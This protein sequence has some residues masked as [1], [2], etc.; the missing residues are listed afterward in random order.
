ML[1][2]RATACGLALLAT[3]SCL[4]TPT[5]LA[6]TLRGAVGLPHHGVLTDGVA[7]PAKGVGFV[8]L[9]KDAMNWG[10]PR[11]VAAVER[12]AGRVAA[13]RPGGAALVVGDLAARHGGLVDRHRSHR[14]GRDVDLLFYA[15]APDGRPLETPGFV[16]FGPDGLAE[17][18]RGDFVRL[19][20]ERQ[21]LLV[22]ELAMDDEA[23][24]QWLFVSRPVEALLLEYGRARRE[25]V[26]VMERAAS[27]L[28]QP[29]DSAPHDDHLH[30]RIACAPDESVAGCTSGGIRWRWLVPS[31]PASRPSD[32][33][34]LAAL[35]SDVPDPG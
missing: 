22:R 15:T 23:R 35:L 18:P 9:R 8:R 1:S 26:E 27:L 21:W 29:G 4:G 28:R 7:L 30:V 17:T 32:E 10:H 34:L 5:P 14:T 24:V 13:L 2:L 25:P 19:D 33:A 6:P 20:V 16:R 11:L 3:T 31:V 12:A